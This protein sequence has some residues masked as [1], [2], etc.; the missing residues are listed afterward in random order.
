MNLLLHSLIITQS[1]KTFTQR[2][3]LDGSIL[4]YLALFCWQ[5]VC[6]MLDTVE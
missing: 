1:F 6:E 5:N 2:E 4:I 3:L